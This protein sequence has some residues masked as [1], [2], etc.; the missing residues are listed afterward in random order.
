[1]V[2]WFKYQ[3][4]LG[5]HDAGCRKARTSLDNSCVS[6]FFFVIYLE[7]NIA[8]RFEY[9]N[10]Y[11]LSCDTS[12]YVSSCVRCKIIT[13]TVENMNLPVKIHWQLCSPGYQKHTISSGS[14][15]APDCACE[16]EWRHLDALTLKLGQIK[17]TMGSVKASSLSAVCHGCRAASS[18]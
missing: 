2:C 8:A 5:L 17:L 16:G 15:P 1:M 7:K 18:S 9:L 3:I 6:V 13:R 14:S 11:C 4:L 10:L 12:L